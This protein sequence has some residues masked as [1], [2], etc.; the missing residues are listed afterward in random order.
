MADKKS[1]AQMIVDGLV[2]NGIETIH[3][4]PG[5]Q[6]DPFFAAL[7]DNRDRIRTV[8][9]RHEQGAAYMATGAAQATGKPAAYCVVPGPG[10][11]NTTAA[12][13]TA[14]ATGAPVFC[15]V[16]Q[17]PQGL[18]GKGTGQLHEIPDQPG[19]LA[20]LTKWNDMV[21]APSEAPGLVDKAITEL[22]SGRPKP[23]ALEVPMDVWGAE[24]EA[25]EP[26]GPATAN[27]WP[28]MDEDALIEAADLL[29]GSKRPMI[30]VGGGALEAPDEVREIAELMQAPVLSSRLGK[31]ILDS[32][33]P[34]SH[35][36]PGGR[37]L[38]AET[39][40]V[41]GVGTRMQVQQAGWGTDD[42]MKII[43]IDADPEEMSRIREPDVALQGD[44]G[45][46]LRRL[47]DLLATRIDKRADRTDEMLTLKADMAG[48]FDELRP[49]LDYLAA[50]RDAL[51]EDG[52][53]VDELTQVGYVS[54]FAFPT[55]TPRTF[56]TTGYQGTLGWGYPSA[57]GAKLARPDVP[58]VSIAGDGGFMF[59]V[60]ELASAA[61][62]G[63]AVTC[64]LFNDGAFGNVR[65]I[66]ETMYGNRVIA[67][68]LQNPDF[69]K[70]AESFGV[71]GLRAKS[72][73]E[74]RRALN[75]SFKANVPT[76][77]EVPT[78]PMPSPWHLIIPQRVRG[79]KK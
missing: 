67:S 9:T 62:H 47:I 66:Q 43:R 48:V 14:W 76:L 30:V 15:L 42:D 69:Q 13:S 19:V 59:N 74:L 16:G 78:G 35:T 55:Y 8:H 22:I 20:G 51:P 38:W 68:D 64:I 2:R 7:H 11:L 31:G 65:R 10:V 1:T 3:C 29:A 50:I 40:V 23:V 18:I 71:M 12:L 63:I 5:V 75:K 24:G 72:P 36:M 27:P 26:T 21:R 58:V 46:M 54:R 33:H 60:Q 17:I 61:Q 39:D 77:I 32:R 34:F 37:R 79:E 49:Q 41:L 6:N 70:L 53:F 28:E 45:P 44:S 56:L 57:L 25:T 73:E 52:I 4:L